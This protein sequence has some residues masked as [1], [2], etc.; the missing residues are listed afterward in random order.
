MVQ[1]T[2]P[3]TLEQ[4]QA[5]QARE[6]GEW[7]A[8]RAIDV[9]GARAFNRGDPVPSSHVAAGLVPESAVARSTT[10]AARAAA[11]TEGS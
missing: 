2:A 3:K 8:T 10:K 11:D 5:E 4:Y 6:Y 9:N 1:P 7:V